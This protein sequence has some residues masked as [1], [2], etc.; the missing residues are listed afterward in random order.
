M[1]LAEAVQKTS[2]RLEA[3]G[4]EDSLWQAKVLVAHV[5]ALQPGQLYLQSNLSFNSTLQKKLSALVEKRISGIPLQ[6][7][8]GEWDFY[9]RTFKVDGRAL[10]PRP[11]TEL[12]VEFIT[13]AELPP[14]PLIMDVGTG[15]GIIGISLALEI[16]GS[17][18]IGTDISP[19]AIE[20]AQENKLLLSAENF[21]TVNCNLA[22]EPDKQFD[23]IVANLPYIS[24]EE[25]SD[26]HPEV[27]DHDPLQALDGGT[28]GTLL[29]LELIKSA[30]GKLKSGGLI[31][32]ETGYDQEESVPAFFPEDLW[33]NIRTHKDMAGNHRMVTARRR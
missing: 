10:I 19:A 24:S 28:R 4:L 12:L 5:V 9:G 26:L 25:I 22:E 18:V 3:A 29:I 8:T 15:S 13:T 1:M 30:P 16:P 2:G 27:K 11:E 31:V 20:L 21:S 6:H 32:L 7:V 23:V 14:R 33:I 17:R